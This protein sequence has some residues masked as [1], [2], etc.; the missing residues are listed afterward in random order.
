MLRALHN[1]MCRV[2]GMWRVE[3]YPA[4]AEDIIRLALEAPPWAR[5]VVGPNGFRMSIERT[6]EVKADTHAAPV[7]SWDYG[8]FSAS[9]PGYRAYGYRVWDGPQA[10][11]MLIEVYG[12]GWMVR[13][14][15]G[16]AR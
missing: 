6:G 11:T 1:A 13:A 5:S 14:I 4:R 16:V 8:T 2:F 7:V 9:G 3:H 12:K 15:T 10:S